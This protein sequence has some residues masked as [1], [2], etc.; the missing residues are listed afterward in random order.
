MAKFKP[1]DWKEGRAEKAGGECAWCHRP[2]RKG[3]VRMNTRGDLM[4]ENCHLQLR[5][6]ASTA[7]ESGAPREEG[8]A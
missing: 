8:A 6:S 1:D 7:L 3:P 4:H 5:R 2:I